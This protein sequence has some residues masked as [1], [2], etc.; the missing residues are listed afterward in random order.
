MRFD[1]GPHVGSHSLSRSISQFRAD[2]YILAELIYGEKDASVQDGLPA[3]G[4]TSTNRGI[5]SC[6]RAQAQ[7]AGQRGA[8]ASAVAPRRGASRLGHVTRAVFV[9]AVPPTPSLEAGSRG[10][11]ENGV[12]PRVET[13]RS[14]HVAPATPYEPRSFTCAASNSSAVMRPPSRNSPSF[15]SSSATLKPWEGEEA[16]FVAPASLPSRVG[17]RAGGR[18]HRA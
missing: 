11:R 4:S 15:L 13:E 6:F 7:V 9:A 3:A 12:A 14:G 10:V 18:H 2:Q 1:S 16:P 5:T 17:R 8:L